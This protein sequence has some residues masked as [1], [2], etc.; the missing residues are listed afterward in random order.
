MWVQ[1]VRA[2]VALAE[3][4]MHL[5]CIAKLLVYIYISYLTIGNTSYYYYVTLPLLCHTSTTMSHTPPLPPAGGLVGPGGGK[6]T[7][8]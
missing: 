4:A 6:V 2:S 1:P 3:P 8:F 7:T 5:R